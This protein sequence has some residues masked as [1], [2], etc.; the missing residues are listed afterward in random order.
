MIVPVILSG[1]SGTR[2]WPLS[3]QHHPKQFINLINRTSLFQDTITRLPKDYSEPLVVCNEEHRFLAAE[4]LREIN[5]NTK[6]IILEPEGRNTAPAIALSAFKLISQ[7]EDPIMLVLSADHLIKN[8][9]AFHKS[10]KIASKLAENGKLVT[11]GILPDKAETGYGYIEAKI[12]NTNKYYKIE[13]FIEKPNERNA[14]KY[15]KSGRY[16]WNSG[17]FMFKA[18]VILQELKKF[19]PE[20]FSTCKKA[21]SIENIDS[22]FIRIDNNIFLNC[23]SKSIDYAV[24]EHTK[25]SLVVPLEATWND[26]G[27]W[28]SLW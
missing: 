5:T 26:V 21:C 16:L 14:E 7:D 12:D 19:E 11:F 3:R 27:S 25:N 18:S 6:G 13:S 1:G 17:M 23:P 9:K 28:S 24:M 22:D 8:D 10:I 20:I 2:L 4:Q 15:L